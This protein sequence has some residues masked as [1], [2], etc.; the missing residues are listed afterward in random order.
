MASLMISSQ[1]FFFITDNFTLTLRSSYNSFNGFFHLGH[2]NFFLI[3]S[4][5]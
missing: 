4:C 3:T 1:A 5:C 2:F